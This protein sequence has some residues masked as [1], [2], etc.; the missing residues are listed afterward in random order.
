MPC[1]PHTISFS[2]SRLFLQLHKCDFILGECFLTLKP[3]RFKPSIKKLKLNWFLSPTY[4]AF[5]A[6]YAMYITTHTLDT[7]FYSCTP[8]LS[9]CNLRTK[10]KHRSKAALCIFFT[11][12]QRRFASAIEVTVYISRRPWKYRSF[13]FRASS[14]I[15]F[16][17][18]FIYIFLI[19]DQII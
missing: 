6:M 9:F 3:S 13:P 14:G 2:I 4:N 12:L 10:V 16:F 15:V 5:Y 19:S 11:G 17:I 7:L 18:D 8:I 1:V